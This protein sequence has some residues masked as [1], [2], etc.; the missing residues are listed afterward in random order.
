MLKFKVKLVFQELK[1]NEGF[2]KRKIDLERNEIER[3][4]EIFEGED[5]ELYEGLK[6]DDDIIERMELIYELNKKEE[7]YRKRTHEV[8]TPLCHECLYPINERQVREELEKI[9]KEFRGYCE[10]CEVEIGLE[11]GEIVRMNGDEDMIIEENSNEEIMLVQELGDDGDESMMGEIRPEEIIQSEKL[12][13][14]IHELKRKRE[15]IVNEEEIML[16]DGENL[17]LKQLCQRIRRREQALFEDYYYLGKK[18]EERLEEEINRRRGKER[19][20]KN[21]NKEKSKIYEEMFRTG[22]R[23]TKKAISRMV[24]KARKTCRLIEGI[25]REKLGSMCT[26]TMIDECSV[27][28]ID[29]AIEHFKGLSQG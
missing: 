21:D 10:D 9:G 26:I 24:E 2:V 7:E 8:K 4:I 3:E 29:Q 19:K 16:E 25:G 28:E 12:Q 22:V 23:K 13:I 27:G 14:L 11:I 15:I 17:S 6:R 20:R 1:V 5:V 18:F